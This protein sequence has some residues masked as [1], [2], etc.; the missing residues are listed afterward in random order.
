MNEFLDFQGEVSLYDGDGNLKWTKHNKITYQGRAAL[1]K[2]L[3]H[4]LSIN[5]TNGNNFTNR[6]DVNSFLCGVAFGNG[7]NMEGSVLCNNTSFDDTGLFAPVPI[8]KLSDTEVY[9][10]SIS[11][12]DAIRERYADYIAYHKNSE[13]E[14]CY[15]DNVKT[16]EASSRVNAEIDLHNYLYFKKISE[17]STVNSMMLSNS[18]APGFSFRSSLVSF[19]IKIN[20]EDFKFNSSMENFNSISELGLYLGS[21]QYNTDKVIGH[22][23]DTDEDIHLKD[24]P[25]LDPRTYCQDGEDMIYRKPEYEDKYHNCSYFVKGSIPVMFSHIT[26]PAEDIIE[27][28]DL[29]FKYTIFV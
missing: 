1:L 19:I 13:A 18:N 16:T 21:L 11:E 17:V 27:P 5:K 23:S 7:G 2:C 9:T 8:R 3:S 28:K 15:I 6:I 12:R 22:N 24:D 26:F 20:Q 10:T 29:T 25:S 4:A 14:T